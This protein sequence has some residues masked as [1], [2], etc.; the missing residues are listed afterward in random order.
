MAQITAANFDAKNQEVTI[1]FKLAKPTPSKSGKTLM[2]FSTGGFQ[3]LDGI[4]VD[5]KP[6]KV[7]INAT[8]P[9]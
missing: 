5:G 8:I 4:Q 1:T 2:V 9:A 3:G 7:S 6:V